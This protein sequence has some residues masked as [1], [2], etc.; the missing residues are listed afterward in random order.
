L[1]I[2]PAKH[3][4]VGPW[5]Y[6]VAIIEELTGYSRFSPAAV[7]AGSLKWPTWL[8]HFD[9]WIGRLDGAADA[10]LLVLLDK[11]V[12]PIDWEMV[13]PWSVGWDTSLARRV[14]AMEVPCEQHVKVAATEAARA[15]IK[16]ITDDELWQVCCSSEI[17]Q[18]LVEFGRLVSYW[19]GL[20]TRRDLL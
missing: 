16:S 3:I 12:V 14:D 7:N 17:P 19:S 13:F 9:R 18:D 2:R 4:D 6:T 1:R 8:Y 11:T 20:C 10:N 5:Y 15:A